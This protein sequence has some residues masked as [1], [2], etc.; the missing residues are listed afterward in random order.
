[1]APKIVPALVVERMRQLG[2]DAEPLIQAPWIAHVEQR[3]QRQLPPLYRSLVL[4]FSFFACEFGNVELFGNTGDDDDDDLTV[5]PFRDAHLSSWLIA[6]GYI[7]FGRSASGSYDPICFD[8]SGAVHLEPPVIQLDH[9]DI[10]LNR[11]KVTKCTV[12][13][14]FAI[15]VGLT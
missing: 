14:N 1:V 10:L 6:H 8:Y 4:G 9:E 5:A 15:L 3:F 12:A 13:G 7:H 2:I 11:E